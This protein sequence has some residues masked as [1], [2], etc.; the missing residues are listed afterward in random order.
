MNKYSETLFKEIKHQRNLT[1]GMSVL[2]VSHVVNVVSLCLGLFQ[3]KST[4]TAE[5][6]IQPIL[7]SHDI[8]LKKEVK[9]AKLN[10]SVSF[11][12]NIKVTAQ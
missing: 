3:D 11:F 4:C 2:S 6:E 9:A 7:P 5:F 1:M 12:K 10:S 8:Q